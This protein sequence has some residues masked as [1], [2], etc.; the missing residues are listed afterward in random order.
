MKKILIILI[1]IVMSIA[2]QAKTLT[3]TSDNTI[4]LDQPVTSE[5]VGSVMQQA[6][7]LDAK[8]QSGYPI[9]LFLYTPGGSIQAGIELVEFLNGLNR[10]VETITL[11]AA[12]MGF[13]IAQHMG[14]RHI[15]K[16]GVLMSHKAR[17]SFRGDFGGSISQIDTRYGLWLRRVK[18]MDEQTVLRTKG[19]QTLKTY[20]DAYSPELWLNGSE[21]VKEG[22][23]DSVVTIKCDPSLD[24]V[25]ESV[26][27][28]GFFQIKVTKSTCPIQTGVIDVSAELIT[29]QGTVK[30]TD[31]LQKN[32]QFGGCIKT[33]K[34][35]VS[36]KYYSPYTYDVDEEIEEVVESTLCAKDP[37]L[38]LKTI[39]D[40]MKKVKADYSKD[41]KDNVVYSY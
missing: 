8:L 27:D 33:V 28:G 39:Q 16:Y 40:E 30:L 1:G 12:S 14:K 36:P 35:E 34:K 15:V 38:S 25:K 11:F 20:T 37:T 19:K 5:S 18:M 23:A 22:Y 7:A 31:F 10:P 17:G 24:K 21:A 2:V 6:K 32:G 26:E 4:V 9:Y 29:N 3:L 13:Q 41:P